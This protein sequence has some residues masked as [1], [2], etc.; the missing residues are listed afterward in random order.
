MLQQ[1]NSKSERSATLEKKGTLPGLH[2][3]DK[4]HGETGTTMQAKKE[5]ERRDP[6]INHPAKA[7][8]KTEAVDVCRIG[9]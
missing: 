2:P 9:Y 8:R 7:Q 1:G 3:H 5:G 6:G 4:Q